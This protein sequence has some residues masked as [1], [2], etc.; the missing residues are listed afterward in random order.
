[1]R[2]YLIQLQQ[3]YGFK[4]AKIFYEG[5]NFLIAIIKTKNDIVYQLII[6]E[7]YVK[8]FDDIQYLLTAFAAGGQG[9]WVN[10]DVAEIF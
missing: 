2:N 10:V 4:N 8:E 9:T 6:E 5:K 7:E 3:V 1:M